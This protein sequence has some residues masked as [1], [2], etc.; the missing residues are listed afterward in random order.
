MNIK[1]YLAQSATHTA[2]YFRSSARWFGLG[3]W[4][5]LLFY[6]TIAFSLM[7][8]TAHQMVHKVSLIEVNG[9]AV[10]M[11]RVREFKRDI[12]GVQKW[13]KDAQKDY[14]T[15][16]DELAQKDKEII[17]LYAQLEKLDI[18]DPNTQDDRNALQEKIKAKN[19]DRNNIEFCNVINAQNELN[20]I[21]V[22]SAKTYNEKARQNGF[23]A[24]STL[25]AESLAVTT[26]TNVSDD[27]TV[28]ESI[29]EGQ[30]SQTDPCPVLSPEEPETYLIIDD[31]IKSIMDDL[32]YFG[33]LNKRKDTIENQ[34]QQ[35][36][37]RISQLLR[38]WEI[39]AFS[40]MPVEMLTIILVLSMGTLGGSI[41]LTRNYLKHEENE[42]LANYFFFPLLGAVTAFAVYILAKAGVLIIADTGSGGRGG[43]L[44][45]Y[46]ISFIGL[47][48]GML[49]DNAL[50]TIQRV[51]GGWFKDSSSE[52]ERWAVDLK[53]VCEAADVTAVDIANLI[54]C[55]PGT[56]QKWFDE[57]T[58][59]PPYP[60]KLIAARLNLPLRKLFSDIPPKTTL[61]EAEAA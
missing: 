7:S 33:A 23:V 9:Q 8:L 17:V 41:R 60:Q 35:S 4:L 52:K 57:I 3:A 58:P 39:T 42:S 30:T 44:S 27:E 56:V 46:F 43:S 2:K 15:A 13:V 48:S 55:S 38:I 32:S 24:I 26:V 34:T 40:V 29:I 54:E 49:A 5:I 45:P 1:E 51:G 20:R 36:K 28:N 61:T 22:L 31:K 10:S 21:N 16:L 59:V 12:D 53:Q 14:T 25:G 6:I 50:D 18:Q 19:T 11:T 37:L 47:V